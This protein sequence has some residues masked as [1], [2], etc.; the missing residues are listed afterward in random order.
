MSRYVIKNHLGRA[1]ELQAFD[2]EGY[3]FNE[4]LSDTQE[5]V[6]TRETR[7]PVIT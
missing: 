3:R 4:A 2:A 5:W 6:F 1:E 7:A